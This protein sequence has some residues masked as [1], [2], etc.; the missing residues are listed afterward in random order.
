MVMEFAEGLELQEYLERYRN[1]FEKHRM[2][3]VRKVLAALLSAVVHL[4][5]AM[6]CHKDIKPENIMVNIEDDELISLKLVDF[7]I[8][9]K[10]QNEN[11]TMI[12]KNGTKMFMAPEME[13]NKQYN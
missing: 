1:T 7:N 10:A 9:Q 3:V 6:I 12:A 5:A 13:G 11:F 8:S 4:H 2:T